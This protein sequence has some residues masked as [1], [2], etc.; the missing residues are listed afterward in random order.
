[1]VK[2]DGRVLPRGLPVLARGS[3]S[4]SPQMVYV[5]VRGQRIRER[6]GGNSTSTHPER[7]QRERADGAVQCAAA[8]HPSRRA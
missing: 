2:V 5:C 4:L 3:L 1:M 7:E 6:G 8:S